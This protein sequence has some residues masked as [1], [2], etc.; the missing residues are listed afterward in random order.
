MWHGIPSVEVFF[1]AFLTCSTGRWAD[2]A[3]TVQPE[4]PKENI[5]ININM[6]IRP[7]PAPLVLVG[8]SPPIIRN[9]NLE[10]SPQSVPVQLIEERYLKRCVV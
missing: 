1:K 5:N 4:L 10:M 6:N 3:D 8:K 9:C 7:P 2:T